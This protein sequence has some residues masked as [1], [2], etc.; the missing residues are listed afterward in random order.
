MTHNRMPVF[1]PRA[2]TKFDLMGVR[3]MTD[4]GGDDGAGSGGDGDRE[5]KAPDSQ[6]ALNQIIEARLAR[7]RSKF[8]DYDDLKAAADK[9]AQFEEAKKTDEQKAQ[10]RLEAAERRAV[11]LELKADRAE[12]AAAKGVPGEL[13]SGSSREEF[14]ASAVALLEFK[15]QPQVQKLHIPNEG[16]SP[17]NL[18]PAPQ[19]GVP[20]LA[21]AFDEAIANKD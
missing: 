20:R 16:R 3:F 18:T 7:E 19:P 1:G 6:E 15:G 9:L 13:L 2:F 4:P 11:E 12:V 14:E 17:E 8:A 5:F 21:A 10:E